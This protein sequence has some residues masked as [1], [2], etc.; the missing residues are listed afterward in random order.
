[1]VL[2][3]TE[4]YSM[5]LYGAVWYLLVLY[6]TYS[7]LRRLLNEALAYATYLFYIENDTLCWLNSNS[8]ALCKTN[9]IA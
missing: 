4:Y 7:F 5:V 2:Y 1:M 9:Y 3:H 6:G 8:I